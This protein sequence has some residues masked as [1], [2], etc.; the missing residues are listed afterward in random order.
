MK[1]IVGESKGTPYYKYD[2]ESIV[3]TERYRIYWDRTVRTDRE[4]IHNRP[5]IIVLDKQ[6]KTAQL[7]DVAI[8]GTHNVK[9]TYEEK[10]RKY[11]EL[12]KEIRKIW[13]IEKVEVIPIVISSTGLV[14]PQLRENLKKI[15][16]LFEKY[17]I[18]K[19]QKAI[20]IKVCSMVRTFFGEL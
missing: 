8:P 11:V 3:E 20:V 17:I 16:L 2:P 13:K 10:K 4:A 6:E 18:S 15:G 14:H 9:S 1:R 12:S 7:I 5:D 19:M